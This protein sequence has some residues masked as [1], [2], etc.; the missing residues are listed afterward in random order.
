[1]P[2]LTNIKLSLETNT[3]ERETYENQSQNPFL[4]SQFEEKLKTL[5]FNSKD[6]K[7]DL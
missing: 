5:P 6:D 2:L 1:M 4:I 7:A 3:N